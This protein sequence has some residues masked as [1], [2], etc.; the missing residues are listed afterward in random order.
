MVPEQVDFTVWFYH[1][2]TYAGMCHK[3][4]WH[5]ALLTVFSQPPSE[6]VCLY[7]T[8]SPSGCTSP[9]TVHS[10]KPGT[11]NTCCQHQSLAKQGLPFPFVHY[12]V[13]GEWILRNVGSANTCD[14]PAYLKQSH[15]HC[16]RETKGSKGQLFKW[17]VLMNSSV[18]FSLTWLAGW[19]LPHSGNLGTPVLDK[20]LAA[21]GS[22][23]Y[24]EIELEALE[25]PLGG[26]VELCPWQDSIGR[27]RLAVLLDNNSCF[28]PCDPLSLDTFLPCS[29]LDSFPKSYLTWLGI[30]YEHHLTPCGNPQTWFFFFI[31]FLI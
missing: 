1:C 11:Q 21:Y 22:F 20:A 31:Y 2:H 18:F 30:F 10:L 19:G 14:E 27:Q 29:I 24:L 17:C 9:R 3:Y 5:T 25:W 6:H 23:W 13:S 7:K 12:C 4:T 15:W 26:L 8:L 28:E 16:H